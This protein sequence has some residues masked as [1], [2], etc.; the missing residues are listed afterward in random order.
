MTN[1][2]MVVHWKSGKQHNETLLARMRAAHAYAQEAHCH[3]NTTLKCDLRSHIGN[4][5]QRYPA[6]VRSGAWAL[7]PARSIIGG[8][9]AGYS[10]QGGCTPGRVSACQLEAKNANCRKGKGLATN[11]FGRTEDLIKRFVTRRHLYTA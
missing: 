9:K 1:Q 6:R 5:L 2:T 4:W 10:C 3:S 8:M 11:N 7:D